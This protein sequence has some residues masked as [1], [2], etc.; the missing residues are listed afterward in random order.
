MLFANYHTTYQ[1]HNIEYHQHCLFVMASILLSSEMLY[2]N[3]LMKASLDKGTLFSIP[4]PSLV[5]VPKSRVQ[6]PVRVRMVV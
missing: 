3:T 1:F 4:D 2:V 6:Q 5:Q